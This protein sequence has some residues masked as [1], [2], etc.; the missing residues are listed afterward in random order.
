[1]PNFLRDVFVANSPQLLL[2]LLY[3]SCNGLITKMCLASEW[4][5]LGLYHK[6]LRVSTKP[7]GQQRSTYFLQLPYRYAIPLSTTSALLHWLASQSFFVVTFQDFMPD[8]PPRTPG[9][10]SVN[11]GYS[12]T[13]QLV[14]IITTLCIPIPILILGLKKLPSSMP[15][16]GSCSAAI[17]AACHPRTSSGEEMA[18]RKL[19][20]GVIGGT[21]RN[22]VGHCTFT[23]HNVREPVVH[24]LYA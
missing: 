18:K 12:P 5:R 4:S 10:R 22:G 8:P 24:R 17:A 19:R 7:V 20:W 15:I 16:A 2:T 1:V 14:T 6:G 21:D 3:I 9:D 23:S 11:V 13:A